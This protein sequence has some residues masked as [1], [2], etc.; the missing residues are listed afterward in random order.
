MITQFPKNSEVGLAELDIKKMHDEMAK[1]AQELDEV[2]KEKYENEMNDFVHKGNIVLDFDPSD[3]EDD[4]EV[5]DAGDEE[6]LEDATGE[7]D[8]DLLKK[9]Y[10]TSAEMS[11]DSEVL[12]TK[13]KKRKSQADIWSLILKEYHLHCPSLAKVIELIL[14]IPSSTAEV[15]RFFKILKEMKTKKRNRLTA[16][17]LRKLFLIY[18][19]LD[20][21]NYDRERV[22]ALFLKHLQK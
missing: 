13:H 3:I 17:K 9:F 5:E 18:H 12:K 6:A 11:D 21:D 16:K 15:E 10:L 7:D 20:L 8:L 1:Y 22:Y 19:F 4:I 14:V 2:E